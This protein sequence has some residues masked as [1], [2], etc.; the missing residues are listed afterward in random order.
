M[1]NLLSSSYARVG[2]LATTAAFMAAPA[3][4][5]ADP[6]PIEQVFEALDVTSIVTAVVATGVAATGIFLAY[7]GILFAK[8]LIGRFL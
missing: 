8:R 3:M 6:T 5:Q 1:K 4:A 2:A 7:R